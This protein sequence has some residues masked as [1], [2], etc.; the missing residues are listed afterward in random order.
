MFSIEGY[1][2]MLLGS[3]QTA[4][5]RFFS[6]AYLMNMLKTVELPVL[7]VLKKKIFRAGSH[8]GSTSTTWVTNSSPASPSSKTDDLR[9]K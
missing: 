8:I 2:S 5:V 3:R 9:M 7:W 4:T 6:S 1:L